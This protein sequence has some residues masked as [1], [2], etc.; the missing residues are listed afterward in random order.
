MPNFDSMAQP[1]KRTKANGRTVE[2]LGKKERINKRGAR[3]K[4]TRDQWEVYRKSFVEEGIPIL[5]M[6]EETTGNAYDPSHDMIYQRSTSDK[7]REQRRDFVLKSVAAQDIEIDA[8]REVQKHSALLRLQDFNESIATIERH[9]QIAQVFQGYFLSAAP[10][11]TE[12]I[13]LLD[14][15]TL[16]R[17]DPARF[18]SSLKDWVSVISTVTDMERKSRGISDP[19][20]LID[21]ANSP[22]LKVDATLEEILDG[23][24]SK[25][26]AELVREYLSH[27]VKVKAVTE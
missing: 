17:T 2:N 6:C 10:K 25:D 13:N 8:V 22:N 1:P 24:E 18:I 3:N 21:I 7:W 20:K 15:N 4:L 27:M 26:D 19:A 11:I 5:D 12:A 23:S 16:A 9:V 14:L